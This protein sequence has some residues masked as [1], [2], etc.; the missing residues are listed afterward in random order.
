MKSLF[1]IAQ[2]TNWQEQE[3]PA[4][5]DGVISAVVGDPTYWACNNCNVKNAEV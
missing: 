5:V 2:L 3:V 4:M 1:A